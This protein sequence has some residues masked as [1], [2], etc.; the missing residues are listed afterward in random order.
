MWRAGGDD[1]AMHCRLAFHISL[2][3]AGF[4]TAAIIVGQDVV[5][6]M[7]AT[8]FSLSHGIAASMMLL[9]RCHD[10]AAATAYILRH[11]AAR[12]TISACR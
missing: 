10:S 7:A 4:D 6:I 5:I 9:P 8:Y 11:D 2:R 3:S 12:F 1:A